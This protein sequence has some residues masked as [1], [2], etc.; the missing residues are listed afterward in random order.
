MRS[1]REKSLEILRL[2]T[3]DEIMNFLDRVV[4]E[5]AVE[6]AYALWLIVIP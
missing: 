3:R 1:A 6:L 4:T 5:F 2:L